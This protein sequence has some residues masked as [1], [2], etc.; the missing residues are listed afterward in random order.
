MSLVNSE[1]LIFHNDECY[2]DLTGQKKTNFQNVTSSAPNCE[3]LNTTYV[4]LSNK[5]WL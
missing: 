4:E 3:R 5:T 1:R 2:L